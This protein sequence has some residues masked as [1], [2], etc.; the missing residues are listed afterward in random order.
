MR[1]RIG[2]SGSGVGPSAGGATGPS[3][4]SVP[5]GTARGGGHGSSSGISAQH[6][7]R[8]GSL[9]YLSSGEDIYPLY[10]R[11]VDSGRFQRALALLHQDIEQLLWAR[12][13]AL[14]EKGSDEGHW[15]G[16]GVSGE[17]KGNFRGVVGI[18]LDYSEPPGIGDGQR[19]GS[20]RDISLPG[21]DR[22]GLLALRVPS[23]EE[24]L[25]DLLCLSERAA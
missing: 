2:W 14:D 11:K 18:E 24:I 25:R 23:G 6:Y 21:Y 4:S 16:V 12:Q 5:S 9:A 7:S 10:N 3:Q 17:G 19:Q 22:G 8:G 15:R 1:D 20:N 13:T